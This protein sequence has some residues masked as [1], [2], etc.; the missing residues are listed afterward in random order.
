MHETAELV[1]AARAGDRAAWGQLL[2]RHYPVLRALCARQLGDAVLAEVPPRRRHSWPSSA[3][4]TCASHRAS[5]L[6]WWGSA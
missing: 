4:P 3:S 2:A 6:G 1:A 5:A